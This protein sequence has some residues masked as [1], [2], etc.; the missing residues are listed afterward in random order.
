MPHPWIVLALS[1]VLLAATTWASPTLDFSADE[2]VRQESLDG[3]YYFAPTSDRNW[4]RVRTRVGL[5]LEWQDHD[6]LAT[7]RHLRSYRLSWLG[8]ARVEVAPDGKGTHPDQ[9]RHGGCHGERDP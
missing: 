6:H 7:A 8:T 9:Y 3:V 5:R 4:I 2:R 1:V